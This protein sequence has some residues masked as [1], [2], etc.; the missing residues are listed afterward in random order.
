MQAPFSNKGPTVSNNM[1]KEMEGLRNKLKNFALFLMNTPLQEGA[2]TDFLSCDQIWKIMRVMR[3]IKS[4]K[5]LKY[6]EVLR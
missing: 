1:V 3:F 4:L 5:N 6:I 2:V